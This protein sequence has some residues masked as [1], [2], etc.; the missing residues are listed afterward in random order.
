LKANQIKV[1]RI[2]EDFK[3]EAKQFLYMGEN[4][5]RDEFMKDLIPSGYLYN[6]HRKNRILNLIVDKG[7]NNM[8]TAFEAIASENPELLKTAMKEFIYINNLINVLDTLSVEEFE[9]EGVNTFKKYFSSFQNELYSLKL[10]L[11]RSRELSVRRGEIASVVIFEAREMGQNGI[12]FAGKTLKDNYQIFN[13][14]LPVY[15]LGFTQQSMAQGQLEE[16]RRRRALEAVQGGMRPPDG[17]APDGGA[18]SSPSG[19]L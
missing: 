12:D 6:R 5:L 10:N 14:S 13:R 4:K 3:V 15:F 1:N 2:S 11:T 8:I 18:P 19:Y 7:N 9:F 17:G 16:M